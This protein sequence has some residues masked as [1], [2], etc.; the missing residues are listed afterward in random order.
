MKTNSDRSLKSLNMKWLVMLALFDMLVVV[1][2]IVPDVN[3]AALTQLTIARGLVTTVLPVVLLLI[4]GVLSH[5]AKAVLV[6]WKIKN[7]MP[8]CQAFTKYG[9]SDLRI[10]MAALKKNVGVLP[11]EPTEQN[12]KWF[13]L[14][15][16][17]KTDPAVVEAHKLYLMYRDMAAMSLPLIVLVPLGLFI[18]GASSAVPWIAA[19]LFFLQFLISTVSARNSGVR[20]VCNVLA[21]HSAKK[22]TTSPVH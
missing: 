13:K 22:V 19:G 2:F 11:T 9:P 8:G 1:L 7:V 15:Q 4:T 18:Y 6:Y 21:I 10:D 3:T 12:S 5:D 17:V 20:F 14:Y 16:M